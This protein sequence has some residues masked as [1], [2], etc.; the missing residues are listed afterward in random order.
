MVITQPVKPVKGEK[1]FWNAFAKCPVA[2][3][4]LHFDELRSPS[5]SACLQLGGSLSPY[6]VARGTKKWRNSY[7]PLECCTLTLDSDLSSGGTGRVHTA[8]LEVMTAVGITHSRDVIVKSAV[9]P[10]RRQRIRREYKKFPMSFRGR[11]PADSTNKGMVLNVTPAERSS[12]LNTIRDI[13]QAGIAHLDLRAENIMVGHDGLPVI[14][15]FEGSS[16]GAEEWVMD[17]EIEFLQ[18][19]LDGK[20]KGQFPIQLNPNKE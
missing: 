4:H 15:D 9:D 5:P 1:V 16:V 11:E 19:L 7:D 13:H 8:R 20:I 3:V 18:E 2:L 14:I 6:G 17:K 10:Y 12:C